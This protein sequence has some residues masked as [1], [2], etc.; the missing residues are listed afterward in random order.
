MNPEVIAFATFILAA[1][2]GLY[3]LCSVKQMK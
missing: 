3:V 1:A 2:Y